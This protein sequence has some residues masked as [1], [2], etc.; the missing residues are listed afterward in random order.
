[1][2]TTRQEPVQEE[3]VREPAVEDDGDQPAW[4]RWGKRV[5]GYSLLGLFAFIFIMPFL[6]TIVNSL[7]AR[8]QAA[9]EPLN[10]IPDPLTFEAF[11][12]LAQA[13][14]PR[15]VFV[16]VVMTALVTIM[17]LVLNSMAGY[18]LAR[19][20]F[21][22]RRYVFVLVVGVLMVPAIVLA[23]PRFIVMG[24]LG[25]LNSWSGLV[26]PL[27][28]DA[29]GIFMMRQFFQSI[30]REMEEAA[31]LDG[32]TIFETFRYVVLPLATPGL[33]ALTI[34]SFQATWNE[35]LHVLIATP[36]RNDLNNLPVGLALLRGA[37]GQSLDFPV[38]L[39]GSLLTIIPVAIVFFVFQRYFVQGV[40]ASGIKG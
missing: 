9:Q 6:L 26:V 19:L 32:A 34:L 39:G 4:Q 3:P 17:R 27:G 29:F 35:F 10:L 38:L 30:P 31:R 36:G 25:M 13:A 14:F 16:T 5:L 20:E 21:P 37:F 12:R 1:M 7:K 28:M 2:T 23:I 33:I 40:A 11:Q 18:A 8:P 22:G 24:Q 15:W